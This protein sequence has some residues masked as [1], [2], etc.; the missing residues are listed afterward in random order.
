M[1]D[2]LRADILA[3]LA[4]HHV[5]T[6]G[7][8]AEGAPWTAAVFYASDG[9]TLYFFSDPKS[10]HC[11]NL[12]HNPAAS[13][14]IHRNYEDWRAIRGLQME[15]RVEELPALEIPAAMNVYASKFP[16]VKEFLTP[17]GLF[18]IGGKMIGAK[19]YKFVPARVYL[20]DNSK[21]FSHREEF[22]V[23]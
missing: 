8:S 13:A 4:E 7:T 23:S 2:R 11:A 9:L 10:R 22:V 1:N 21:G 14:A 18:Q 17:Q 15:G 12:K 19:F 16:F 3:Y 20:L 6:L 5:M